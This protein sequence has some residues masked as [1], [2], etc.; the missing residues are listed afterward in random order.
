MPGYPVTPAL[1]LAH[2][3]RKAPTGVNPD[4]AGLASDVAPDWV[5]VAQAWDGVHLGFGGL[6]AVMIAASW[7]LTRQQIRA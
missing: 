2:P 5:S 4:P 7:W 3:V 1:A 6:L